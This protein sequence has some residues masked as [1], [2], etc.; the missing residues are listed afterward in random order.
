MRGVMAARRSTAH[1][2]A[3]GIGNPGTLTLTNSTV[4]GN[5]AGGSTCGSANG[6]SGGRSAGIDNSGTLTLISSTISANV[7]EQGIGDAGAVLPGSG[8][9]LITTTAIDVR[10]TLLAGNT[11]SGGTITDC[12][13]R[14]NSQGYTLIGST[15]GCQVT[16]S[17]TGNRTGVG[18]AA[19]SAG[20][21]RRPYADTRAARR[22]PGAGCG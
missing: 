10:N 13:G 16:G 20:R 14:L 5:R 21:Q 22:Q 4:S 3:S 8:G 2:P 17:T 18:S 6:A 15:T 7:A 12:S 1:N 9:G 19:G 11:A